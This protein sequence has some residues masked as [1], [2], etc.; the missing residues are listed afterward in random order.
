MTPA[1]YWVFFVEQNL[2]GTILAQ[3]FFRLQRDAP[4]LKGPFCGNITSSTKP[5]VHNG[6]RVHSQ[7]QWV[8]IK[9][10]LWRRYGVLPIY[11]RHS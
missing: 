8:I 11:F 4:P 6:G 1:R 7:P 9:R 3:K 5:E 10:E 2:D